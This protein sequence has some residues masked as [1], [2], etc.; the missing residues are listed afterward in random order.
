MST[1]IRRELRVCD[2]KEKTREIRLR[3]YGHVQRME[4]EEVL[5]RVMEW[6]VKGRRRGS[7]N[8]RWTDVNT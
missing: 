3:W 2:I 6:K 5:S 8:T 4:E 7:L 1:D